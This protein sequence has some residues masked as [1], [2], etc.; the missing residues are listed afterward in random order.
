MLN[1]V[2][3]SWLLK[4][5]FAHSLRINQHIN[6]LLLLYYFSYFNNSS[7][8]AS[9]FLVEKSSI[10]WKYKIWHLSV[11]VRC[12]VYKL[13]RNICIFMT[14]QIKRGKETTLLEDHWSL[15][16]KINW[17][18]LKILDLGDKDHCLD[19]RLPF[20]TSLCIFSIVYY[21]AYI[22]DYHRIFYHGMLLL[23]VLHVA[24]ADK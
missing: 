17:L 20:C 18:W 21:S 12:V 13:I 1:F 16:S 6:N 3:F 8:T 22:N 5:R 15:I 24:F 2:S 4:L 11:I 9:T 10:S 19:L 23:S 14:Q 7:N